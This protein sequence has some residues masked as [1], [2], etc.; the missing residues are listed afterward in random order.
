MAVAEEVGAAE[1]LAVV[2]GVGVL[3]RAERRVI[4]IG[5]AIEAIGMQRETAELGIGEQ[6]GLADVS[7][8]SIAAGELARERPGR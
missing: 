6:R 5:M 1:G 8:G 3:L 2:M 7:R 4:V